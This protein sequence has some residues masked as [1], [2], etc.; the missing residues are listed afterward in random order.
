MSEPIY[1][2][3]WEV[4]GWCVVLF[5]VAPIVVVI[6]G[7]F[8]SAEFMTFPPKGLS[9]RWY[10]E[11]KNQPQ[12]LQGFWV[13]IQLGVATAVVAT[14][15]GALAGIG[16]SRLK[17]G[18]EGVSVLLLSPLLV[19]SVI[20][21]V[22]VLQ[23]LN[24]LNITSAFIALLIGHSVTTVPYVIRSV[25]ASVQMMQK[26]IEWAAAN[27]GASPWRVLWHVTL[28]NIRPGVVGGA[29]FAFVVS[30]D[31]VTISIFLS[32][33]TYVPL[34]VRLYSAMEFVVD[35]VLASLSTLLILF[36]VVAV[37]LAERVAGLQTL[38]GM[39]Y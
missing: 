14:I 4:A 3:T 23:F 13:S 38:F 34:P 30:F 32:S 36:S 12:F 31:T 7:S 9:L 6:G 15:I 28:P 33:A 5:I 2:W 27:L 10:E 11:L 22:A 25:V 1:R 8:T 17:R 21:G 37:L 35:P 26:D 29:I 24:L 16:L 20:I 19:P 39:K 18:S